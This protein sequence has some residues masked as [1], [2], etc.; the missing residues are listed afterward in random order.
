[1]LSSNRPLSRGKRDRVAQWEGK[2]DEVGN[3][4][5]AR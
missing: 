3:F 5:M 4:I 1:M 2:K